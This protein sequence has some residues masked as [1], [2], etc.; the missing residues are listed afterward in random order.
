MM[1]G[2]DR[3]RG[4]SYKTQWTDC[5]VI[6]VELYKLFNLTCGWSPVSSPFPSSEAGGL[7]FGCCFNR[8]KAFV[9]LAGGVINH[10]QELNDPVRIR[11]YHK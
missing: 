3:N 4:Q 11:Y 1:P 10:V 8:R 7:R 9:H 5:T 6:G 2:Q